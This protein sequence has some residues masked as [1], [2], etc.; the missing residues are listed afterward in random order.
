MNFYEDMD[1]LKM[2]MDNEL[3]VR[4]EIL[5]DLQALVPYFKNL[6]GKYYN[7]KL[8]EAAQVLCKNCHLY[9]SDTYDEKHI[10]MWKLFCKN[11]PYE[12]KK[13]DWYYPDRDSCSFSVYETPGTNK[14]IEGEETLN[15]I[16][17]AIADLEFQIEKM[18]SFDISETYKR[19]QALLE[20]I[21][22]HNKDIPYAAR[23]TL[24]IEPRRL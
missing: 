12:N 20:Q 15:C 6:N 5:T 17:Q 24:N 1:A 11:R 16:Q 7:K 21:E 22:E 19:Q 2:H 3:R 23:Q 13:G 18:K 14:R 8:L 4:Q 10:T 9:T